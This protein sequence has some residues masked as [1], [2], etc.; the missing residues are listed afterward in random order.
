MIGLSSASQNYTDAFLRS[1]PDQP[2]LTHA[3]TDTHKVFC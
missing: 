3:D 1:A 2:I